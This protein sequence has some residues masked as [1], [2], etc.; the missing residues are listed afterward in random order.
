MVDISSEALKRFQEQETAYKSLWEIFC[1]ITS[2]ANHKRMEDTA[3]K[4][5]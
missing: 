2:A 4:S 5:L 3:E 1:V